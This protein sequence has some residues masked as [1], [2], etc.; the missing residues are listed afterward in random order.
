[1]WDLIFDWPALVERGTDALMY[2][3]MAAVGT[4]F[5]LVR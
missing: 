3:V 2:L 1:M 4:L 5:F